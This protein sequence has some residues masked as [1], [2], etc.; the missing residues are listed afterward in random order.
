MNEI[1]M[2]EANGAMGPS[3]RRLIKNLMDINYPLSRMN[4]MDPM[5]VLLGGNYEKFSGN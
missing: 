4:T 5:T 3:S 2:S 1:F